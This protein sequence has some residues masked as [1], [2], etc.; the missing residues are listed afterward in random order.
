MKINPS[1]QDNYPV[2]KNLLKLLGFYIVILQH[3]MLPCLA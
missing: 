3:H 2:S 1:K